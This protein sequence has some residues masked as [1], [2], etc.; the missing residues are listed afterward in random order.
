MSARQEVD[1]HKWTWLTAVEPKGVEMVEFCQVGV[2][3]AVCVAAR[4]CWGEKQRRMLCRVRGTLRGR[5]VINHK[6]ALEARWE[7][8]TIQYLKFPLILIKIFELFFSSQ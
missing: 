3:R 6:D 2:R 8:S 5:K 7:T 4:F 1:E